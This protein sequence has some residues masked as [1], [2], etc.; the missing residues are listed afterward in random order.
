MQGE[1]RATTDGSQEA[2]TGAGRSWPARPPGEPGWGA[3]RAS[4]ALAALAVVSFATSLR[5]AFVWDDLAFHPLSPRLTDPL[6]IFRHGLWWFS[7]Q[8]VEGVLYRP[9]VTLLTWALGPALGER[10]AGWHAVNLVLHGLATLLV[11][12]LALRPPFSARGFGAACGA[13]LFAVHPVHVEAVAY[14]GGFGHL[15]V[16][17]LA[18]LAA[19]AQLGWAETGRRRPLAA[20][21]A[22]TA[23]ALLSSEGAIVI[24]P[25][26]LA[27]EAARHRGWPRLAGVAVQGA[28]VVAVFS[29]RAAVMGPGLPV[30]ADL[31]RLHLPASFAAAYARNLILPWPQR[32]LSALPPGGVAGWLDWLFAAAALAGAVALVARRRGVDRAAPAVALAWIAL[33]VA[34]LA[35]AAMNPAPLFA[36]R[37]LYLPSAG[38][39]LLVAWAARDL[40]PTRGTALALAGAAALGAAACTVASEPWMTELGVHLRMLEATPDAVNVNGRVALLYEQAGQPEAAERTWR[41]ALRAATSAESRLASL[42]ALASLLGPAGRLDEAEALLRRALAEDPGRAGA[43]VNLGNVALARGQLEDAAACYARAL[44]IEPGNREALHNGALVERRRRP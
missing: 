43:W 40:A 24:P 9:F 20:A 27:L 17:C 16:T 8:G 33:P 30:S 31:S 28:A 35:A 1:A 23:A 7:S 19:H 13:V 10:P 15:V 11:H 39:A 5:G 32:I 26:L 44:R 36:P 14:L 41:E 25:L 18:L 38:L 37:A 34:P 4:A 6:T 42:E 22:A 21:G 29:L 12:R 3:G 2:V